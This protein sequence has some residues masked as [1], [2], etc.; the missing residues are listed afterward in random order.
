MEARDDDIWPVLHAHP[1]DAHPLGDLPASAVTLRQDTCRPEHRVEEAG[2]Y[3]NKRVM[4]G[5]G[6]PSPIAA[7]DKVAWPKGAD[8]CI[9]WRCGTLTKA[10]RSTGTGTCHS[11]LTSQVTAW[12][13]QSHNDTHLHTH[14]DRTRETPR[15]SHSDRDAHKQAAQMDHTASHHRS[16]ITSAVNAPAPALAQPA[17]QPDHQPVSGGLKNSTRSRTN[18]VA[19]TT[20]LQR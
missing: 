3:P 17:R 10:T 14:R 19:E 7:L 13:P 5:G 9:G 4:H 15:R 6:A 16:P 1:V 18:P 2:E 8:G 12:S 20:P 11:V